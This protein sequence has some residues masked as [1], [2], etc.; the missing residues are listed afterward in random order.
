MPVGSFAKA[1]T[2]TSPRLTAG[3]R[4]PGLP[5]AQTSAGSVQGAALFSR[6]TGAAG[7]KPHLSPREEPGVRLSSSPSRPHTLAVPLEP[8]LLSWVDGCLVNAAPAINKIRERAC[9]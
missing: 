1:T 5:A 2:R 6:F 3:G 8:H 4:P 7:I 9:G